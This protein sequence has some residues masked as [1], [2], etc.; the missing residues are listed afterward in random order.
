MS[1]SFKLLIVFCISILASACAK[2]TA[3]FTVINTD[4]NAPAKLKFENLSKNADSFLWDFGDG[5]SSTEISPAHKFLSSGRHY[6]KLSATKGTK[7]TFIQKEILLNPPQDC[8]VELETSL[9]SMTIQLSDLTPLHRDNFLNL[10]E[11]NFYND[12]LFHRVINGFM[13]QTGDP[14][15]KDATS[16]S[17]LGSGGVSYTIPAEFV[18]NLVHVKGAIAA[19]RTSDSVNPEKRSSGSQFY[20][21]HGRPL[22]SSL[23]DDF[24]LQKNYKLSPTNRK[25]YETLGGSPQLD[26]EYTVFG[27]VISGLEIIDKICASQTDSNDRPTKDIKIIKISIIN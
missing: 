13:I 8:L 25:I 27:Q 2:P 6:I 3:L 23:L 22:K 14:Q 20:I 21:T 17:K 10:V 15:S 18:N 26:N 9:G 5:Q 1:N 24:E 12:L 19:A 11:N 4:F 16:D 7:T